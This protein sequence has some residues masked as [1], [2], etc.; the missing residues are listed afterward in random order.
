MR[1]NILQITLRHDASRA[2]QCILQFGTI[3][4]RRL[5]LNEM[6]QRISEVFL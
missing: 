2:V 6:S 1:G 4:Q 5:I 3:E